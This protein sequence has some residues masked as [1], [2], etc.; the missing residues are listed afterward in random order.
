VRRVRLQE[1]NN[2]LFKVALANLDE[3]GVAAFKEAL[4]KGYGP[5]SIEK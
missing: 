2:E 3:Q 5:A 4:A 1:Y